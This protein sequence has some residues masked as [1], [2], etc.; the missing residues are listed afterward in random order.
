VGATDNVQH[1]LGDSVLENVSSLKFMPG[2]ADSTNP[3]NE[4]T[5]LRVLPNGGEIRD[6]VT[7]DPGD[8]SVNL[9]TGEITINNIIDVRKKILIEVTQEPDHTDTSQPTFDV[10]PASHGHT[11]TMEVTKMLYGTSA[12]G[13]TNSSNCIDGNEETYASDSVGTTNTMSNILTVN[14]DT[15][16]RGTI[17]E[18]YLHVKMSESSFVA[19]Y[20]RITADLSPTD[21][22]I[23]IDPPGSPGAWFRLYFNNLD[24][25]DELDNLKIKFLSN[26][27]NSPTGGQVYEVYWE[28]HYTPS[29][30]NTGLTA[31]INNT[32]DFTQQAVLLGG[33]TVA[34]SLGGRVIA[35]VKGREDDG[36]GTY[37]GTPSQLIEEPWD[38]IYYMW[39][40][41]GN[42]VVAGDLDLAGSYAD[43]AA[44]FPTYK[45]A[46][47]TG[48]NQRLL[49]NWID[50][51]APQTWARS[52]WG[53][54][55][56]HHLLRIKS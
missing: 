2:T 8:W 29:I 41:Y 49:S 15:T 55:G 19:Q 39:V 21:Q 37:T 54:D 6:A 36:S 18:A 26:A 35:D 16:D 45:W 4:I 13:W 40:K 30:A 27:T 46:F 34:A 32:V 51:L 44:A 17:T 28:V 38:V 23:D 43:L 33:N 3:L 31:P 7:I 1:F 5:N 12:S 10:N 25:W 53:A 48:R 50:M 56:K 11:S 42:G 20:H 14:F 22:D 47:T 24:S 9:N 52:L